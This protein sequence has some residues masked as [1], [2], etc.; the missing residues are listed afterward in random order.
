VNERREVVK[1]GKV[2]SE[3]EA[4]AAYL[5]RTGLS[6]E[7][8][9]LEACLFAPAMYHGLAAAGLPVVCLDARHLKAATSVMPVKTDR[10]DARNIACALQAGWYRVVHVNSHEM[11]MHSRIYLDNHVRGILKAF[12]LKAGK[13]KTTRF[14]ARMRELVAGDEVLEHAVGVVL[15]VRWELV[16][17][18]EE[19]D[20]MILAAVRLDP[21]SRRL[22]TVPSVDPL[23]ALAF[24]TAVE[25]PTRFAKS[26]LVGAHFGLTP[27]KYASGETDRNGR[28]SR[29]SDKMVRSLLC[30]AANVL[31]TRAQRWSW[32]KRWAIGVA[33][34]RGKMR[35]HVA[36]AR[37]LAVIMH[38]MWVDDTDFR[39]T[40]EAEILKEAL[41]HATGSKR[42]AAAAAVAAE[43]RVAMKTAAEVIGVSRSNLI[44]RL[45]S[46]PRS[47][48]PG[49]RCRTTNSWLRSR[50]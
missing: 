11:L 45:K 9:G 19:I 31:L 13:V 4:I 44:E 7:R 36:L 43:G 35:A 49:R 32:L 18:L 38:R 24:R 29:C 1:E 39:W 33:K 30:E 12:G 16:L 14:E 5:A 22:M 42:T 27:R 47:G 40:R 50:L 46:S 26:A 48:S 28:I 20:R 37:R 8:I 10:I 34:R 3:T 25:D 21:V 23:T 41:E 15:A 6:F 17:R 2:R